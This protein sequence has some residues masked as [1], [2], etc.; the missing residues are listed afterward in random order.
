MLNFCNVCNQIHSTDDYLQSKNSVYAGVLHRT[1]ELK[2]GEKFCVEITYAAKSLETDA[3]IS[4]LKKNGVL[5]VFIAKINPFQDK[6]PEYESV[7]QSTIRPDEI[8]NWKKIRL[9]T[10]LASGEEYRFN[11]T[12]KN[13][14]F[15]IGGVHFCQDGIIVELIEYI[16]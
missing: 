7:W 10:N 4:V 13:S 16:L 12:V 11:V 1:I 9:K 14:D 15:Y 8:N 2:E 6:K 3:K 5:G